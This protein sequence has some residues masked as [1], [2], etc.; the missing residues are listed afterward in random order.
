MKKIIAIFFCLIL[1]FNFPLFS[2]STSSSSTS[3]APY[4]KE[5]FPSFLHDLRR[6]E[7]ITFGS[8]PF[9]TLGVTLGYGAYGYFSGEFSSF[10]NPLDKGAESFSSWQQAKIFGASL[11]ISVALGLLDYGITLIKRHRKSKRERAL[12]ERS[13]QIQIIPLEEDFTEI[14]LDE[15]ILE[16]GRKE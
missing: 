3:P 5:E 16:E 7:I 15:N 6:A 4:T 14:I 12:L 1:I 2:Q 8:L 10:P 13:K 9:V 11:G